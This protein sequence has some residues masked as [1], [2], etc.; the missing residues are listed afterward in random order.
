[1]SSEV[2]KGAIAFFSG[3]FLS[4]ITGLVRD[5]SMAF[6]FGSHPALAAFMV[7]YRLANVFRRLLGEGP[8]SSGL[9]P[10]FESI[11]QRS[12]SQ[13]AVFFRDLF[14]SVL[15]LL[16]G[17]LLASEAILLAWM[18]YSDSYHEI[19]YSTF[20]MM[21]GIVFICLYGIC[22]SLLQCEKSFFLPSVAPI[23]FN[24]VWIAA[25][26]FFRSNI[27]SQVVLGLSLAVVVG[28]FLQW[29][30]LLPS[31]L[32]YLKSFLSWKEIF[33]F[34]AFSVDVR[35]MIK[36]F[37]FG[38]IGASGVQINSALDAIF[39]R[40]ASLEGPAYLWYAIRIQ[41]LPIALFGIA[42]SSALLPPLARALSAEDFSGFRSLMHFSVRRGCNF[43][44]PCMIALF[45]LA[46]SGVN[47]LYGRGS[48]DQEATTQ[49]IYCLWGYGA[50]L[51][52]T[53]GV[54]FLTPAF[55]SQ[56]NFRTPM[57]AALV[58]ILANIGLNALF[59]FVF[60]WGAFSIAL[61]TSVAAWGNFFL[62]A[63]LL[64]KQGLWKEGKF[65]LSCYK[66][67]LAS[68]V[69]GGSTLLFGYFVLKD[70]TF[71]LI[72]GKQGVFVR[73]LI[74]QSLEF[75]AS[76]GLFLV[77]IVSCSLW[78]GAEDVLRLVQLFTKR[79]TV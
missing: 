35:S 61:S 15:L 19:L 54:L 11:R 37:L 78:L 44:I 10:Y 2:V 62:L 48:F 51:F 74:G 40:V 41:Q 49:T 57:W 50:G 60:H 72:L 28:F 14:F 12:P 68:L 9:V 7:A 4:R 36:P 33:S 55:Y 64:G 5:V 75:F 8:L 13:G 16:I 52:P 3:T 79:K 66:T 67:A 21:P 42:V 25:V 65:F 69:A 24:F 77:T 38:L 23:F 59:V 6:C 31:L 29:A 58:S 17:V 18:C 1:M 43:I 73:S 32:K 22:S 20:L 26:W 63:Y 34:R 70:P 53:L 46:S 76:T 45:V 56:K 27:P 71:S 47:L 39:S 30:F